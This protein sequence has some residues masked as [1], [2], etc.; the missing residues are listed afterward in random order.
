LFSLFKEVSPTTELS[1]TP[2][3]SILLII[4][5]KSPLPVPIKLTTYSPSNGSGIKANSAVLSKPE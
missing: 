1:S 2:L 4:N 3:S 5:S